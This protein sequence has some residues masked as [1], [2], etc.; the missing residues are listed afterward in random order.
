MYT[1]CS[2]GCRARSVVEHL[3][4][5]QEALEFN[6]QHYEQTMRRSY[7]KQSHTRGFRFRRVCFFL[8]WPGCRTGRGQREGSAIFVHCSQLQFLGKRTGTEAWR[9]AAL[10]D[11]ELGLSSAAI[12]PR[13]WTTSWSQARTPANGSVG[14]IWFHVP[15]WP[16][17][18]KSI[19]GIPIE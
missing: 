9:A 6:P 14:Q 5:M 3:P 16:E 17:G 10:V 12:C 7:I 18:M 11:R 19:K 13:P 2:S 4:G 8:F 15:L 1:T